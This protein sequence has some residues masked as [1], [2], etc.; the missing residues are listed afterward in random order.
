MTVA[1]RLEHRQQ[2][3][4]RGLKSDSSV[5]GVIPATSHAAIPSQTAAQLP[6]PR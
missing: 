2:R 5:V 6:M 4:D 3:P 1:S